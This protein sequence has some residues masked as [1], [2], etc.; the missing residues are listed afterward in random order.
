MPADMPDNDVYEAVKL[1]LVDELKLD[2]S[3]VRPEADLRRDLGLD[4]LDVTT[5][6][7]ALEERLGV[8]VTDD[9]MQDVLTVADA[10]ALLSSHIPAEEPS[11]P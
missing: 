9:A 11:G 10:V 5:V 8:V 2:P 3:V 6:A 4:S 1:V 7:M